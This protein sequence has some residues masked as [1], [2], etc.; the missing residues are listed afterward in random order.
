MATLEFNDSRLHRR[1][2]F[3]SRTVRTSQLRLQARFPLRPV[4]PHPLRQG[5][6]ADT[7]FAGDQFRREAFLQIQ[8]NGFAP[9]LQ[10]VGVNVRTNRPTRRPPR[11]AGSLRL[12]LNFLYTFH[13]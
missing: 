2:H 10:W 8:L 4:Q 3:R 12:P 13:R 7:H 6:F 11:G 1:R 5:A 9:D